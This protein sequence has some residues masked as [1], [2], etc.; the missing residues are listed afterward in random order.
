MWTYVSVGEKSF[1]HRMVM[2]RDSFG[3]KHHVETDVCAVTEVAK[4]NR[5]FHD[6]I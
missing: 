2:S 1:N 3:F 6:I 5:L 4:N